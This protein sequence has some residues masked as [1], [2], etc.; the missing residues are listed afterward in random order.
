MSLLFT[1]STP[2]LSGKGSPSTCKFCILAGKPTNAEINTHQPFTGRSAELLK[3]LLTTA[4]IAETDI[5]Y[6]HVIKT[7]TSKPL[8]SIGKNGPTHGLEYIEEEKKLYEE[9]SLLN[10]RV[11]IPIDD[12]ALY[13]LT[14]EYKTSKYRGSI[15]YPSVLHGKPCVPTLPPSSAER[16]YLFRH[17][18]L[19]DLIKARKESSTPDS[20]APQPRLITNPSFSESIQ[21]IRDA[22]NCS[23][24]GFDIETARGELDCF[25]IAQS[26]NDSICIPI[27]RNGDPAFSAEEELQILLELG[28]LLANRNVEKVLQNG[29][30]DATFLYERYGLVINSAHDTMIAHGLM[31]PD[32]PKSLAFLNS[33]YT[34]HPFYKDDGKLRFKGFKTDDTKFWEYSARDS[35]TTL[36]IWHHLKPYLERM[37]LYPTYLSHIALIHPLL[38]MQ[39]IGNE[40]DI[41]SIREKILVLEAE[42]TTLKASLYMRAGFELNP[43]SP[44]QLV[45]YFYATLGL[46]PYLKNKTPTTDVT[47]MRRLAR[48]GIEEARLIME[49]RK[50]QKFISTYLKVPLDNTRK[51][52]KNLYRCSYNPV[53][54]TTGRLSSSSHI[55]G[56]GGNKQNYPAALKPFIL[57]TPDHITYSLDLSSAENRIVAYLGNIHEMI[58]AFENDEDVHCKTA[59][60]LY[61]CSP[62]EISRASGSAGIPNSSKSQRDIGKMCNHSGNYGVGA[63]TLAL[64][65]DLPESFVKTCLERYHLIYPEVRQIFQA[66]IIRQ[67]QSN[68]TVTNLFGRP[69]KFMDRWGDDLFKDAFAFPAQST[70]ADIITRRGINYIYKHQNLSRHLHLINQIHDSIIFSIPL[71]LPIHLHAQLILSLISSLEQPLTANNN[72]F[73]IPCDLTI[74]RHNYKR[75]T[76]LTLS[77]TDSFAFAKEISRKYELLSKRYFKV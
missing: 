46:P 20:R 29:I 60:L 8:I 41:E 4:G 72:T 1:D 62:S 23:I 15:L 3:T 26:V 66:N 36:E 19:H 64:N 2:V 48:Q 35:L 65:T 74:Y 30:Y 63:R 14:R 18:M 7:P 24:I 10:A 13:A 11:Y 71:S 45:T 58:A 53:G 69:R 32:F 70:I 52:P 44:K 47:A 31:Y 21:Y 73:V 34:R 9:L 27:V 12:I 76:D 33:I 16:N 38:Q 56:Y 49:I 54:T 37:Q 50:R 28:R 57:C 42:I 51:S 61:G 22:Y 6:T 43:A 40:L 67:L 17:F 39:W 59:S 55:L 75:S 25:S 5:Y 77:R 68:R